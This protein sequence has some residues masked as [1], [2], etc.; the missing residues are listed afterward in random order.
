MEI[1]QVLDEKIKNGLLD[2]SKLNRQG[3]IELEKYRS[4]GKENK[5]NALGSIGASLYSGFS[6]A[7]SSGEDAIYNAVSG[8]IGNKTATTPKEQAIQQMAQQTYNSQM[9]AL[10]GRKDANK[11]ASNW[12][13]DSG[14]KQGV[15]AV[16][17]G[18]GGMIP[19]IA[20]TGLTGSPALGRTMMAGQ[21]QG[22][23]SNEMLANGDANSQLEATLKALPYTAGSYYLEGLGG[24]LS[25]KPTQSGIIGLGRTMFEEGLEEGAESL[26]GKVLDTVMQQNKVQQENK[27]FGEH[28]KEVLGEALIGGITGGVLDAGL[29]IPNI[30]RNVANNIS[31]KISNI[32]LNKN[33]QT[34]QNV[35][36]TIQTSDVIS[37]PILSTTNTKSKNVK[38]DPKK[39]DKNVILEQKNV[40]KNENTT[41]SNIINSNEVL[42]Q[43]EVNVSPIQENALNVPNI[44]QNFSEEQEKL[45][46][47]EDERNEKI[48]KENNAR[49]KEIDEK[50]KVQEQKIKEIEILDVNKKFKKEQ[51]KNEKRILEQLKEDKKKYVNHKEKQEYDYQTARERLK[52]KITELVNNGEVTFTGQFRNRDADALVGMFYENV[53]DFNENVKMRRINERNKY[54]Y[55]EEYTI[56]TN[57][58]IFGETTSMIYIEHDGGRAKVI[59]AKPEVDESVDDVEET[60][61]ET[62]EEVKEETPQ[63]KIKKEK[64]TDAKVLADGIRKTTREE[65]IEFNKKASREKRARRLQE[66][67]ERQELKENPYAEVDETERVE[68]EVKTTKFG[69]D[70]GTLK[71]KVLETNDLVFDSKND[72]QYKDFAKEKGFSDK[73]P[74]SV[75]YDD[76][77]LTETFEVGNKKYIVKSDKYVVEVKEEVYETKTNTNNA[78]VKTATTK[79][80]L[81]ENEYSQNLDTKIKKVLDDVSNKFGVS[82]ELYSD[83]SANAV[84]G[85]FEGNNIRVNIDGD[86]P[87]LY[88]AGHEIGHT[89]KA[90]NKEVYTELENLVF[91]YMNDTSIVETNKALQNIKK[92]YK[93]KLKRGIDEAHVREEMTSDAIGYLLD[94]EDIINQLARQN[95][96]VLEKIIDIID[97]FKKRIKTTLGGKNGYNFGTSDTYVKRL[98]D[99]KDLDVLKDKLVKA[100]ETTED[101]NT[102]SNKT[103][104]SLKDN[105]SK[106]TKEH[107]DRLFEDNSS[108]FDKDYSKAYI[109]KINIDDFINL[110]T[111]ETNRQRIID[112]AKPLDIEKLRSGDTGEMFIE[113]DLE[114]NEVVGHEGRHRAVALKNAGIKEIPVLI[115]PNTEKGKYNR[116]KLNNLTLIGQDFGAT[117]SDATVTLGEVIPLSENY[118]Q[119]VYEK[120]TGNDNDVKYSLKDEQP[121]ERLKQGRETVKASPQV[122]EELKNKIT[123]ENYT[124]LSNKESTEQ[125]VDYINN[126][127]GTTYVDKLR[128]VANEILNDKVDNSQVGVTTALTRETVLGLEKNNELDLASDLVIKLDE[129]LRQYGREIQAQTLWN[130]MRPETKAKSLEKLVD[131]YNDEVKNTNFSNDGWSSLKK[132]KQIDITD[133]EWKNI[134]QRFREIDSA[135][136]ENITDLETFIKNYYY[137]NRS[138]LDVGR[139]M[140]EPTSFEKAWKESNFELEQLKNLANMIIKQEVY[141][142]IPSTTSSKVATFQ[143]M[144]QLLNPKTFARNILSN[145]SFRAIDDASRKLGDITYSFITRQAREHSS[146]NKTQ[147]ENIKKEAKQVGA[148][149]NIDILLGIS[150]QG[151]D[152]RYTATTEGGARKLSPTYKKG[153]LG[154]AEKILNMSLLTPDETIKNKIK[155]SYIESYKNQGIEITP[156]IEQFAEDYARYVTFQDDSKISQ[157]MTDVKAFL[158]KYA[159][160]KDFGL[161]D[162]YLKYPKVPGNII[163]RVLEYSPVGGIKAI[164]GTINAHKQFK[165]GKITKAE[166]DL[167]TAKLGRFLTGSTLMGIGYLLSKLGLMASENDYDEEKEEIQKFMK[168]AG[169]SG[170]KINLNN[171]ARILNGEDTSIQEGDT[172]VTFDFIEPLGTL[173]RIGASMTDNIDS[174]IQDGITFGKGIDFT[175]DLGKEAL[176]LPVNQ[177]INSI[178]NTYQYADSELS[179]GEKVVLS[180]MSPI[181]DSASGFVPALVREL[182]NVIEPKSKQ[183]YDNSTFT[184]KATQTVKQVANVTPLKFFLKD[185][186]R[187]DASVKKANRGNAFVNVLAQFGPAGIS[188][189]DEIEGLDKLKELTKNADGTVD[190]G[191]NSSGY[192]PIKN[193]SKLDGKRLSDGEIEDYMKAYAEYYNKYYLTL[194]DKYSEEKLQSMTDKQ[195]DELRKKLNDINKK[196]K[197]KA[198]KKISE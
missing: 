14:F 44:E 32:S 148:R 179:Q 27:S 3:Q 135:T 186:V 136:E 100:L 175:F 34:V 166:R 173:V 113:Y 83:T 137:R 10:S 111:S 28:A 45:K 77:T 164:A 194:L 174:I 42:P 140:I 169:L 176:D 49:R 181:T 153:I 198:K 12:A 2:E 154:S 134:K 70:K 195:R 188:S 8:I 40:Q 142:K 116:T 114:T 160:T 74:T 196:A 189:Y 192:L 109:T 33:N 63:E 182:T 165:Q 43:N 69:E 17:Q 97:D 124:Q 68:T 191:T 178:M 37:T 122:T 61:E 168:D 155:N 138:V 71:G 19:S 52:P 115:K 67:K 131:K 125:A 39:V 158:N 20:V 108:Q 159:G 7:L 98:L 91:D 187:A 161:G 96:T 183:V 145:E 190:T 172:L 90:S 65:Q 78:I 46:K 130:A 47:E 177:A 23:V 58:E 51:L 4:G 117:K 180:I 24:L 72:K 48:K 132:R 55:T 197:E 141:N 9:D 128:T 163:S 193:I 150:R 139:D 5:G 31:D 84:N 66:V 13:G 1:G 102:T 38:N 35:Q 30:G 112:S 62:I 60:Q 56:T 15:N 110:T 94:N 50:I 133:A 6:N 11:Y 54:Q 64:K 149:K 126:A 120:F 156:Q 79:K 144:S 80:G 82:I 22:S 170:T 86:K 73:E 127:K 106:Y 18:V 29:R 75:N 167:A 21:I 171:I 93:E 101:V 41:T 57:D 107:L 146:L 95:R 92:R 59:L 157:A 81:I 162:F 99:T 119:E 185:N 104:M 76:G 85:T 25:N 36:P 151:S 89:L 26:Y 118:K 184:G 16:A 143:T 87:L 152:T 53:D 147:K 103:K 88:I 129:T 121:R 123:S 105:A